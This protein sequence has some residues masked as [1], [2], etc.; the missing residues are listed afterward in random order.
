[1]NCAHN[2]TT[3]IPKIPVV[4]F[5]YLEFTADQLFSAIFVFF[6]LCLPNPFHTR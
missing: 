6:A 4:H 1:M 3:G 5:L 2:K